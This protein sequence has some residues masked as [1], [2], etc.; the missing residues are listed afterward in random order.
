M[1][2]SVYFVCAASF[3]NQTRD[4]PEPVATP[5]IQAILNLAHFAF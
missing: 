1:N 4:F 2:N 5:G 3:Y